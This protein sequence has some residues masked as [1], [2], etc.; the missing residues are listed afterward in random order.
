MKP[1]SEMTL[2]RFTS[3]APLKV[4]RVNSRMSSIGE[5]ARNCR[6]TNR[7]PKPAPATVATTIV[8]E[9][10]WTANSLMAHTIGTI[11]AMDS[12][13]LTAST[14]PASG[15]RLSGTSSGAST[16]SGT[17]TG[18]AMRNT[19]PHEKCSRRTPPTIGPSAAPA[20]NIDAQMAIARRR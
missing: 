9:N 2:S 19:D 11:I 12:T 17:S 10:P 5:R 20:E 1:T 6:R 7:M 16:S 3:R 15:L 14:R 13:I 18:T 4:P 8:G